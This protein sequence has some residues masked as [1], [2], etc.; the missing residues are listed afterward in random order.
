MSNDDIQNRNRIL[1]AIRFLPQGS[2]FKEIAG[3]L[4]W[5][6]STFKYRFYK[7]FGS[8]S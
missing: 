4:G 1:Y 6:Y 7:L 2:G 5:N 3:F 8:A